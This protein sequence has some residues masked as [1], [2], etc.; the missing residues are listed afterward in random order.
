MVHI[1]E[2]DDWTPAA[3]CRT[4]VEAQKAVRLFTYPGAYHG[5]D[6]PNLPV[7]TRRGVAFSAI[8][9]S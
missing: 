4:L 2:A 7:K 3:P 8:R 9:R 6:T 1:G 5:F